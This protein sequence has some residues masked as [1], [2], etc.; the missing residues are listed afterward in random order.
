MLNLKEHTTAVKDPVLQSSQSNQAVRYA[1]KTDQLQ[2]NLC[3]CCIKLENKRLDLKLFENH[4]QYDAA[5]SEGQGGKG[6]RA[7]YFSST[8]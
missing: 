3:V 6:M 2:K 1:Y 5:S 7:W 4:N 8:R